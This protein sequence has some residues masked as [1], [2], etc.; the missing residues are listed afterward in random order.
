MCEFCSVFLVTPKRIWIEVTR[1]AWGKS[2]TLFN[3][4]WITFFYRA[5]VEWSTFMVV[6]DL[7]VTL[8]HAHFLPP[9]KFSVEKSMTQAY[10]CESRDAMC[11]REPY[12]SLLTSATGYYCKFNFIVSALQ[13][14]QADNMVQHPNHFQKPS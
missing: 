1:V 8:N 4:F 3:R 13:H 7:V 2:K 9:G 6:F 5:E 11:P 12:N 10:Q 14:W